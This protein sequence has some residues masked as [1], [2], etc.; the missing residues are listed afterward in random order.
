MLYYDVSPKSPSPI[1]LEGYP[2]NPEIQSELTLGRVRGKTSIL[3]NRNPQPI[4]G[5]DSVYT[6]IKSKMGII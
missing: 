4:V 2:E 1:Y 3:N 5:I 6:I